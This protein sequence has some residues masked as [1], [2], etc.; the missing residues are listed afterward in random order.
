MEPCFRTCAD[1]AQATLVRAGIERRRAARK[2]VERAAA[3]L[4]DI[5]IDDLS[6]ES[7]PKYWYERGYVMKLLGHPHLAR[8]HFRN[9]RDRA[10]AIGSTRWAFAAQRAAMAVRAITFVPKGAERHSSIQAFLDEFDELLSKLSGFD[11]GASG[12]ERLNVLNQKAYFLLKWGQFTEALDA[13]EDVGNTWNQLNLTTGWTRIGMSD[14]AARE[15][16]LLLR[17]PGQSRNDCENGLGL[18]VRSLVPMLGGPR[19]GGM[20]QRPEGS[21][22]TDCYG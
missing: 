16:M 6:N 5:R 22:A 12:Q 7:L 17:A 18:I 1:W 10:H 2:C 20:R 11:V 3:L 15:G 8:E 9:S 4:R 13:C 19:R 21:L 14:A